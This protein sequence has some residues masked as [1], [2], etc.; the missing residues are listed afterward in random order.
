MKG[1]GCEGRDGCGSW[2]KGDGCRGMGQDD[3]HIYCELVS[4]GI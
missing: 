4:C 3:L 1:K 2:M